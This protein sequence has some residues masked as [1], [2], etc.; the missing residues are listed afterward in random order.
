MVHICELCNG[1]S[2]LSEY[3]KVCGYELSD[4]GKISDYFDDYSAYMEIDELKLENGI[5][6]DYVQHICTHFF[7]CQRCQHEEIKFI[8]E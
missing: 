1:L 3:C 8:K 4:M 2:T 7:Y 5:S 6:N